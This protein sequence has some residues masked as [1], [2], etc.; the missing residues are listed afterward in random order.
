MMSDVFKEFFKSRLN[1]FLGQ[2]CQLQRRN[3]IGNV[4]ACLRVVLKHWNEKKKSMVAL[5]GKVTFRFRHHFFTSLNN[6][7]ILFESNHLLMTHNLGLTSLSMELARFK[8]RDA[9]PPGLGMSV[10]RC[11][12]WANTHHVISRVPLCLAVQSI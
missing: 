5:Q 10:S 3:K 1:V 7:S 8:Q 4:L 12:N 6:D 2:H 9:K 11:G